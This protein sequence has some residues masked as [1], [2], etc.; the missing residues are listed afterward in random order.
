M[1]CV[2]FKLHHTAVNILNLSL[3]VG[4]KE[5]ANSLKVHSAFWVSRVTLQDPEGLCRG[6]LES[7]WLNLPS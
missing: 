1:N 6:E 2:L 5:S 4:S 7:L 3:L